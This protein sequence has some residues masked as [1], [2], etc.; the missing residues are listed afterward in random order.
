LLGNWQLNR[1]RSTSFWMHLITCISG[2]IAFSALQRSNGTLTVQVS[3]LHARTQRFE[4]AMQAAQQVR[5]P[6]QRFCWQLSVIGCFLIVIVAHAPT[7]ASTIVHIA[8]MMIFTVRL[9]SSSFPSNVSRTRE[10]PLI[11]NIA[12]KK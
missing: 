6:P 9:L 7:Y 4:E 10:V 2:A 5:T 11:A 1:Q 8:V 3:D 12:G